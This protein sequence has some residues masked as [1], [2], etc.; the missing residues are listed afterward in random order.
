[1]NKYNKFIF[2]KYE[3]DQESKVLDL[4]YS[5]D[6]EINFKESFVFDFDFVDYDKTILDQAFFS[7]F[8]MAGVSYYKSFLP[9]HIEIDNNNLDEASKAFFERTYEKGLGEF[10][11]VNQ[12][13]PGTKIN[14]PF[15]EKD[16]TTKTFSA[17]NKNKLI[18]IG[19]GKDSLLTLEILR[20]SGQPIVTW[21]VGH[22]DQ[23]SP[24]VELMGTKH[25]FIDR[26]IDKQILELNSQGAMNGHIPISAILACTGTV[27]SILSGNCEVVVSN[28]KSANEP[29]LSYQG[30]DINHQYS[31]SS[32][33]EQDY[34]E[35]LKSE[36]DNYS[37]Y[38]SFLRPLGELYIAELF[39]KVGFA[40]YKSVFSSCNRAFTQNN[41]QI[42]WCGECAKCAFSF[43]IFTPF[44]DKE[45]LE[46]LWNDKNLLL[47]PNLEKTYKELLGING[48]K[49]LDCVGEIRESRLA[50]EM[51]KKIYPELTKYQYELDDNY[52]YQEIGPDLMPEE[53]RIILLKALGEK[54]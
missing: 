10:F 8:I 47:D 50:M 37:N 40:K 14:F 52:N 39:S 26:I 27:V 35:Y 6:E 32:V 11:Y 49:P 28:E 5:L 48:E 23:L 53:V 38:Y 22:R 42:F 41:N 44:I 24:L 9:S 12:L 4:F 17:L 51:A 43:L 54:N 31:K 36:L 25:L 2:K 7:L 3:F 46:D 15:I 30:I 29:S 13:D 45:E 34:Q 20:N 33:F 16:S 1:M 21:S 19:G 18:G